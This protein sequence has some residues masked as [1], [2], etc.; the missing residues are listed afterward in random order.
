MNI[1]YITNLYP[2]VQ[3]GTAQYAYELAEAM[4]KRGHHV[5]VLCPMRKGLS[6]VSNNGKVEVYRLPSFKIKPFGLLM[7]FDDFS[8]TVNAKNGA[9]A[10]LKE[11]K[12]DVIHQCGHLLDLTHLTP[13]LAKSFDIPCVCSVH[14]KIQFPSA[15]IV[16]KAFEVAD[17]IIV[18]KALRKYDGV[19]A[20]DG[21]IQAYIENRYG[22]LPVELPY[23]V[24]PL[25]DLHNDKRE[26]FWS[27]DSVFPFRITS[28]GHV[29]AMRTRDD[30]LIAC[31]ELRQ[32]GVNLEVQVIGK[33]CIRSRHYGGEEIYFMG[34]WGHENM[35]LFYRASDLEAH[36]ITNPGIGTATLEAMSCGVPCMAYGYEGILAGVPF[37]DGENIL[38]I[39]PNDIQGIRNKIRMLYDNPELCLK[40]GQAGK[41]LVYAYLTWDKV[42]P[43]YEGLYLR[44]IGANV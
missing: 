20:L 26:C 43:K 42:A 4:A 28:V 33:R 37:K 12:I 2:P 6:P 34:E 5:I 29:T 32:D 25:D 19:I 3:T 10:I 9:S 22:I 44:V 39:K 8:V 31:T 1:A 11:N 14:T 13:T 30:L 16:N 35:P 41:K 40:I 17:R 27:A 21:V 36:W 7:G 18:G 24:K 38:F 23:G 15:R